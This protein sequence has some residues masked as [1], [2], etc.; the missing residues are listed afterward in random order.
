MLLN[1]LL[2]RN[3]IN[4]KKYIGQTK[5]KVGKDNRKWGYLKRWKQH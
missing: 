2:L 4:N 5:Q 1:M 3:N